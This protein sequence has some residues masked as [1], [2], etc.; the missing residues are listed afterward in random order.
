MLRLVRDGEQAP[1]NEALRGALDRVTRGSPTQVGLHILE[2]HEAEALYR[3]LVSRLFTQAQLDAW[4][5]RL[6]ADHPYDRQ[7]LGS[8]PGLWAWIKWVI[9]GGNKPQSAPTESATDWAKRNERWVQE[10]VASIDQRRW[11]EWP[12]QTLTVARHQIEHETGEAQWAMPVLR[13]ALIQL[14]TIPS[15]VVTSDIHATG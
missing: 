14:L 2:E 15:D 3:A 10:Q 5:E 9:L 8:Q 6:R 7:A 13:W 11:L 12:L 1:Q 4:I